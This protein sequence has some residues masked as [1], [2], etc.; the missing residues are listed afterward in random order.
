MRFVEGFFK[1]CSDIVSAD[2]RGKVLKPSSDVLEVK[3]E[4]LP[5]EDALYILSVARSPGDALVNDEI[6]RAYEPKDDP[7]GK[8][9]PHC[10][11][12][13]FLFITGNS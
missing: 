6:L 1:D 5:D 12:H 13:D 4:L 10:P 3:L 11:A 7:G 9:Y 8:G 2:Q